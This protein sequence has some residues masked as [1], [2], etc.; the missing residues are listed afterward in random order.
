TKSFSPMPLGATRTLRMTPPVSLE[1]T[2]IPPSR[3]TAARVR[4]KKALLSAWRLFAEVVLAGALVVLAGFYGCAAQSPI[5]PAAAPRSFARE[6]VAKGA[7]LAHLG[8]C[9]GCHTT[10]GGK[11]YAGGTPI[12]T[13]FGTIYGTNITPDPDTGIGR[14]PLEA[15]A[16][17]MR[18]G[19]DL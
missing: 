10:E 2:N 11:P 8:N 15:F 3:W 5:A 7:E 19:V 18:E 6:Q 17:A 1:M 13:P 4:A 9:L 12:K 16:R 14:W